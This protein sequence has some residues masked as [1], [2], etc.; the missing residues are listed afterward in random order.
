MDVENKGKYEMVETKLNNLDEQY[1]E[2]QE[3]MG[4]K[5]LALKETVIKF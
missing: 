2:F 4:K 1:D 5:F 3:I